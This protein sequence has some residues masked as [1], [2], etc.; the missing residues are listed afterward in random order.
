MPN[1]FRFGRRLKLPSTVEIKHELRMMM[2]AD[3]IDALQ[4]EVA[5]LKVAED[6]NRG[7]ELASMAADVA[8]SNP[9]E[10]VGNS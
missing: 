9:A 5:A 6:K 3:S 1:G 10:R 7:L 4:R 8:A 2:L